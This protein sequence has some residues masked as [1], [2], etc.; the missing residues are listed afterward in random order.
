MRPI[1]SNIFNSL[2]VAFALLHDSVWFQNNCSQPNMTGEENSMSTDVKL[3]KQAIHD[4]LKSQINTTEAKLKTLKAR[5]QRAKANVELKAITKLL[6]RKQTI[7]KKLKGLKKSGGDR[8]EQVRADV[9][10]RITDLEKSVKGIKFK[11]NSN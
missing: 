2:A 10:A 7:A 9:E 1:I 11:V 8:F 5:A 6:T 4:K 3:A